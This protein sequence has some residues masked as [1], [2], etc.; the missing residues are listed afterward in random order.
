MINNI[1]YYDDHYNELY[2]YHIANPLNNNIQYG[3]KPV[4]S[5]DLR[6]YDMGIARKKIGDN[7]FDYYYIKTNK[8]ISKSDTDRISA[9]KLPPAWADVWI[10]ADKD[11]N[12]QAIG[13]DMK[14]RKQ[15][16]YHQ[17]HIDDAEREKFLRLSE[18]I[19]A[20]PKLDDAIKEHRRLSAY[21][22]LRVIVSMLQIVSEVHMRVGK[23]QYARENKSYGLSSLKKKHAKISGDTIR[24]NF[25][26][27]SNQR[28]SYTIVN[29]ELS[30]HLQLL[31]SL[32]GDKLFQY[33]DNNTERIAK[34][35]DSDLNHYIQEYMGSE[36]TIKDFRTYG[37]NHHFVKSLLN[38]TKKRTPKDIKTINKNIKYAI[39]TTAYYLRHTKA[40]SKKSYIMNFCMDMYIS[41]PEYFIQ[42]KYDDPNT[43]LLDILRQY[44]RNIMR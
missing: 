31:M 42:R 6:N 17:T 35:T 39:H 8:P 20:L 33:L 2:A 18:F 13:T 4:E 23:E 28:L 27:K 22:K 34:V 7:K 44:K 25:K 19:T 12:I 29:P 26:G 30:N 15:Y 10:S 24:F 32:E 3:G 38:E 43:V 40:I 21:H 36:F 9:L 1:S 41:Q 16:K 37:A 5:Y 11:T 14:G